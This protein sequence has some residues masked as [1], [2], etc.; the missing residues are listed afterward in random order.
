MENLSL[1][2]DSKNQQSLQ[3]PTRDNNDDSKSP[4]PQHVYDD[5]IEDLEKSHIKKRYTGARELRAIS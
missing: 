2:N 3:I 4:Y 5:I 1:I